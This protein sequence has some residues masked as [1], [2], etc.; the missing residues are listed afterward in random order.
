MRATRL[1]IDRWQPL[2][3]GMI[4]SLPRTFAAI[5]ATLFT[6]VGQ[7]ADARRIRPRTFE[8]LASTEVREVRTTMY[9]NQLKRAIV[10]V[11]GYDQMWLVV[12]SLEPGRTRGATPI[13]RAQQRID[14]L[15]IASERRA[16]SLATDADVILGRWK[17]GLLTFHV[18]QS[19]GSELE[20]ETVGT[21]RG[22][23]Q[24]TCDWSSHP[25]P[26]QPDLAPVPEPHGYPAYPPPPPAQTNW[27]SNADVIRACGRTFDGPANEAACLDALVRVAYNPTEMIGACD[28]G[29]DGDENELA[30]VRMAAQAFRDPSAIL[31]ACDRSMDGDANELDC[32]KAASRATYDMS[33]TIQACD[34]AMDGDA[35]E[36]SC[37]RTAARARQDLS[38]IIKE[39]DRA[40]SGDE[41]ELACIARAAR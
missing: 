35:N 28:R 14:T 23:G 17:T 19:D 8:Q 25:N 39:C 12:E 30:C 34:R 6:M 21:R 27:A 1:N 29:M 13:L 9:A 10:S 36:L 20:C 31:K 26:G 37:I 40:M 2:H 24:A 11:D 33:E 5:T 22:R 15:W 4:P 16:I 7:S 41:S 32:A 38:A 18:V 3:C